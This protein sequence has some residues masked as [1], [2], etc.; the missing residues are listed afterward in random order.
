[1]RGKTTRGVLKKHTQAIASRSFDE[2]FQS[3]CHG[4]SRKHEDG[5][6]VEGRGGGMR[7]VWWKWE[8]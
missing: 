2:K 6:V 4:F 7:V 8:Q 1:M 5:G 3:K